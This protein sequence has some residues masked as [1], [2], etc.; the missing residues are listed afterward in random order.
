[1][2]SVYETGVEDFKKELKEAEF[3]LFKPFKAIKIEEK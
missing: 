1:V 2:N 3:S